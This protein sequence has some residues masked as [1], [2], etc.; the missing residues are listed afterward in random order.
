MRR[1]LGGSVLSSLA[2]S[3]CL[4]CGRASAAE[5]AARTVG[6]WNLTALAEAPPATWGETIDGTQQVYYQGEPL[7]GKPTRVFAYYGRPDGDGPFAAMLLVHGG[8]GT[9]FAEWVR[10]WTARGYA[11]LAMDLGGCGPV[12]EPGQKIGPRLPDGG[13]GQSHDYK[14]ANFEDEQVGK[15]W[16]YHAV[17]A[18]VRGHSLLVSLDEVDPDRIGVTGISW[19]G[20]LTCIVAG[21][22]DRLK[23]AVPVYGCGFLHHNST[24]L[25]IFAQ[26]SPEQRDRWVR[27]FDPS[28][29]LPNVR[30]PILF[31]NGTNDFA[32]PLDSYQKSYRAVPGPI[33]LRIEVGMKHSQSAG[34]TPAEIGLFVDSVLGG[35]DP[36]PTL[37]RMNTTGGRASAAFDADVPIVRG[38]LHWTTDSGPW[39]EREWQSVAAE[40]AEGRVAADLPAERPLV[41]YLSITDDRGAMVSTEHAVLSEQRAAD[42]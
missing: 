5:P 41:Y 30:C 24:W 11:A 9:A 27:W 15:M 6:P 16:T 28:Q 3:V 26:M 12:T 35:G 34:S 33:C 8:G 29:Y 42:D 25:K 10:L 21:V 20:Y 39:Q 36:L 40:F 22:D 23:V 7:N 37:A 19:G 13:P 14:F 2:V 31:I 32:Y 1:K 4:L 38:E 18:V 17:A